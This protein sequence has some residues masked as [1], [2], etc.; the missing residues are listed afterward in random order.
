MSD[1]R[2]LDPEEPYADDT[3]GLYAFLERKAF[4]T[5]V[6]SFDLRLFCFLASVFFFF[7]IFAKL[8]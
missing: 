2:S 4:L 5:K 3:L 1:Q 8:L 6:L 7:F